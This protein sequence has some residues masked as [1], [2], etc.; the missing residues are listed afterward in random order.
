V[1]KQRV[2]AGSRKLAVRFDVILHSLTIDGIVGKLI[3]LADLR[4]GSDV[5]SAASPGIFLRLAT[6]KVRSVS[7]CKEVGM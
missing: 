5:I 3:G 6:I 4:D 1:G 7:H 2:I